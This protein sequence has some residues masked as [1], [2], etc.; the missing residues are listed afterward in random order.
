MPGPYLLHEVTPLEGHDNTEAWGTCDLPDNIHRLQA[1]G[2]SFGDPSLAIIWEDGSRD[3]FPVASIELDNVYSRATAVVAVERRFPTDVVGQQFLSEY[4]V[5]GA[6]LRR[7]SPP[8][9]IRLDENT[10]EYS[11]AN[12][13]GPSG[14][15][16]GQLLGRA[17]LWRVNSDGTDFT[18]ETLL[19]LGGRES[20][21][22]SVNG[23]DQVCGWSFTPDG[24]I[25]AYW[26]Q[27]DPFSNVG[28]DAFDITPN[29]VQA[30]AFGI[31][32]QRDLDPYPWVVGYSFGE[33]G[34]EFPS[35]T[36]FVYSA[37]VGFISLA[38]Q[39]QTAAY[40]INAQHDVVGASGGEATLWSVDRAGQVTSYRLK[41]YVINADGWSLFEARDIT[42]KGL[43]AGNGWRSKIMEDGSVGVVQ[44][45][46]LLTPVEPIPF[47]DG[48]HLSSGARESERYPAKFVK[49]KR[50]Q[51][52]SKR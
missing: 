47:R 11:V 31:A 37:S 9:P 38:P 5:D 36:G 22:T 20:A 46:F 42:D 21:A 40:S 16:V 35:T 2:S 7:R 52:D 25:H 6:M 8:P 15:I 3:G 26:W 13:I 27:Y 17:T 29:A 45:G 33:G 1:V 50:V 43:I 12:D 19:D 10:R 51:T 23:W 41:D 28:G 18:S 34:A 30:F 4:G 24:R 49:R 14:A 48:L 32:T 44:R 39:D